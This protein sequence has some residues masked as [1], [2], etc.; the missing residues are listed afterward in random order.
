L[1]PPAP[2]QRWI[3][4]GG[5]GSALTWSSNPE[6]TPGGRAD[7]ILD[8][9]PSFTARM[10]GGRVQVNGTVSLDG[11]V[12]ANHTQENRI[13]P[14]AEIAAKAEAIQRFLFIEGGVRAQQTSADPFAARPEPGINSHNTFTALQAHV[15]PSIESQIDPTTRY[16]L[17][18]S[19]SVTRETGAPGGSGAASGEGYFGR[20][21]ARI[22]HDPRP[23]GWKLEAERS[24]TRYRNEL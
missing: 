22:E 2:A 17:R 15:T 5:I 3:F 10:E 12:S 1:P 7:P 11:L 19:N 24:E 13:Q 20:H 4:G 14:N 9:R 6:L 8:V 18:S 23:L 21:S 16:A